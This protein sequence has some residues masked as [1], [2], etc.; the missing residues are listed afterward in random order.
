M[1][2]GPGRGPVPRGGFQRAGHAGEPPPWARGAHHRPASARLER[3]T[4]HARGALRR[5][6]RGPPRGGGPAG[7]DRR[8]GEPRRGGHPRRPGGRGRGRG[9]DGGRDHVRR[10]RLGPRRRPR[11]LLDR[12]LPA[13]RRRPRPPRGPRDP[14]RGGDRRLSLDGPR[15]GGGG[16]GLRRLR[17]GGGRLHGVGAHRGQHGPRRRHHGGRRGRPRGRD[18]RDLGDPRR[19]G[20]GDRPGSRPL[21]P[22]HGGP[23]RAGCGGAADPRR[24]RQVGGGARRTLGQGDGGGHPAGRPRAVRRSGAPRQARAAR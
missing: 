21:S 5:L 12:P 22:G 6:R 11:G 1:D 15:P 23:P 18:L 2:R 17:G 14:L 20:G 13:P 9:G 24:R 7:R 3:R 4:R 10:G 8:L 19:L 16:P